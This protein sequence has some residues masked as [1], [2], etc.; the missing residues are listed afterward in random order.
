MKHRYSP[1]K[2]YLP[3]GG[4]VECMAT[5]AFRIEAYIRTLPK[6]ELIRQAVNAL[7]ALCDAYHATQLFEIE[8]DETWQ[9]KSW[10]VL[11][12]NGLVR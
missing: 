12:E 6:E 2:F 8:E 5:Q 10:H 4:K 7:D 3:G 11:R 9:A 1:Q